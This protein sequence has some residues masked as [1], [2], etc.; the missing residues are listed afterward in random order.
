M[1][2]KQRF[3]G[4]LLSAHSLMMIASGDCKT[5]AKEGL[6]R[7]YEMRNFEIRGVWFGEYM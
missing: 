7:E 3:Y 2:K 6:R 4:Q 5:Q 1:D